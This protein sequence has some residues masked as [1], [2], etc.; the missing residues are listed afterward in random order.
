MV[1]V[2]TGEVVVSDGRCCPVV[3]VLLCEVEVDVGD[4]DVQLEMQ[5]GGD[6]LL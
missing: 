3:M 4:L 2:G 5:E 1:E 6:E